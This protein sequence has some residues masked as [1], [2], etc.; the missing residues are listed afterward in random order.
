VVFA[1][2]MALVVGRRLKFT[3]T[4]VTAWFAFLFRLLVFVLTGLDVVLIRS[5]TVAGDFAQTAPVQ[6]LIF[7]LIPALLAQ[8]LQF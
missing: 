5:A 4:S 8:F 7:L 6:S 1:P 3:M 2:N